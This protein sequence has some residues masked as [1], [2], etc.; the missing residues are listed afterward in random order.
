[1]IN[2][3]NLE[4]HLFYFGTQYGRPFGAP[5]QRRPRPR[6]C[7]RAT[8]SGWH[9]TYRGPPVRTTPGNGR[10]GG[11]PR[12]E[13][14]WQWGAKGNLAAV[15][16][17]WRGVRGDGAVHAIRAP[18]ARARPAAVVVA[19]RDCWTWTGGGGVPARRRRRTA[20]AG[21]PCRAC[22]KSSLAGTRT[23]DRSGGHVTDVGQ[24]VGRD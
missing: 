14:W 9:G 3:E 17:P 13:G 1:M 6:P 22:A 4:L 7:S 12:R 2:F 16:S 10:R 11:G 5:C 19:R 20:A 21:W 18:A 23:T 8:L 15:G 24:W